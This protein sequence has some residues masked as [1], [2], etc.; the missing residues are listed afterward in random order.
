MKSILFIVL[1]VSVL[2]ILT[3]MIYGQEE[4]EQEKGAWEIIFQPFWADIKGNDLHAGDVYSR[5]YSW[6]SDNSPDWEYQS[7][8]KEN[9]VPVLYNMEGK[10]ALKFGVNYRKGSWGFGGSFWWLNS[11]STAE[12]QVNTTRINDMNHEYLDT[13]FFWNNLFWPYE[14]TRN[15]SGKA[16]VN[17]T[18]ENTID[19]WCADIHATRKLIKRHGINIELLFGGRLASLKNTRNELVSLPGYS[20]YEYPDTNYKFLTE[21]LAQF[22]ADTSADHGTTF[23]PLLGISGRMKTKKANFELVF[24]HVLLRSNLVQD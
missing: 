6:Q 3:T 22:K 20:F 21:R 14:D 16:S 12:G 18:A 24:K 19:M 13:V 15:P 11:K 8:T 17:Y 9:F 7:Y 1:S 23:G 10:G 5:E 2:L 4:Q